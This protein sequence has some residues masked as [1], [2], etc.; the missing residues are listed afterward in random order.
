MIEDVNLHMKNYE[1][2]EAC[3]KISDFIDVLNNWYIRR[4]RPRFWKH[5][6]NKD[7]S[8]AYDTL[9]T[10]LLNITKVLSPLMPLISEE[11]YTKLTGGKSVHL[12]NWPTTNFFPKDDDFLNKM[13]TIREICSAGLSI[14][15]SNNIRVRQPLEEIV[16]VG[17]DLEW[18][19]GF[20]D[21]IL[22]EINIKNIIIKKDSDSLYKE[23]LTI[24]LRKLG[25]KLGKNIKDCLEG[26]NNYEWKINKDGTAKIRKYILL[27]DEY[28]IEKESIPGTQSEEINKGEIVASLKLELNQELKKEGIA[29][30]VLRTIQ[31]KRKDLNFD[32]SDEINVVIWGDKE[33]QNSIKQFKDYISTNVL[34]KSIKIQEAIETEEIN[35][36][37]ENKIKLFIEKN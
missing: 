20:K 6:D 8:N 37:E 14:R 3:S 24:D 34:A 32:I 30:D 13:D 33:V 12:L 5:A 22:E 9:F 10:V 26:A 16:L 4:S 18:I 15:K 21:Y 27:E 23:K 29:R 35:I 11:I 2:T 28:S 1:I 25:P 31:N 36:S 7:S 17:E 19:M